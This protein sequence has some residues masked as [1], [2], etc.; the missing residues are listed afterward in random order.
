M[1][2]NLGIKKPTIEGYL[3]VLSGLKS[4]CMKGSPF[5]TITPDYQ[6]ITFTGAGKKFVRDDLIPVLKEFGYNR[7]PTP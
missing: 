3:R 2:S 4:E 5:I 7:N 1:I 6:N